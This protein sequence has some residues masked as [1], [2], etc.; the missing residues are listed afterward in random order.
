[1]ADLPI[2]EWRQPSPAPSDRGSSSS[3]ESTSYEEE[4]LT[5][6]IEKKH[7]TEEDE[8]PTYTPMADRPSTRDSRTP[9]WEQADDE[10]RVIKLLIKS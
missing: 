4:E 6:P 1:M 3:N 9:Q 7:R 5:T 10:D 2:G 8:D